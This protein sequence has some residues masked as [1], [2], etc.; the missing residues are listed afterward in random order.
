MEQSK[1]TASQLGT[2]RPSRRALETVCLAPD[3]KKWLTLGATLVFIDEAGFS[4][5]SPLKRTWAPRGQTP[6]VYTEL[7]H[8]VRIN[9]IGALAVTAGRRKIRLHAHAYRHNISG[10]QVI[11][12]LQQLIEQI[13]GPIVL[14]WDKHPIHQRVKVKHWLQ[15][16][17]RVH[18]YPFPTSAPE[19]NPTEGVWTQIS[20]Y[21]ASTAPRNGDELGAFVFGGVA[22][23]RRSARRLWA[24]IYA[25]DLP[26]PE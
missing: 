22:R 1:A 20:E 16:H 4:L 21:T 11:R 14:V 9:L 6:T 23:T 3:Q 5:R 7:N 26:W 10:D 12:F 17:P 18:V 2:R 19:L 13:R 25:S 8:N 24:C 15:T